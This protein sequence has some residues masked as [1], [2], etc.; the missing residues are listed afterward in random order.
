[1]MSISGQ[2]F[3]FSLKLYQNDDPKSTMTSP[4]IGA[5]ATLPIGSRL[6]RC[7][8]AQGISRLS[9]C[10]NS[11]VCGST[12]SISQVSSPPSLS[13]SSSPIQRLPI[14]PTT[15]SYTTLTRN[16]SHVLVNASVRT[17]SRLGSSF[18]I[19]SQRSPTFGVG[20]LVG[21]KSSFISGV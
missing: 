1:M 16:L 6:W 19:P 17:S 14:A 3:F 7:H 4:W 18:N 20:I 5:A 8:A 9:V 2:D 12:I 10:G 11:R 21:P 15:R 13:V